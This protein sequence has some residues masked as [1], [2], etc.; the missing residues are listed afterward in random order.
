MGRTQQALHAMPTSAGLPA[1]GPW[2]SCHLGKGVVS[3]PR[4][5]SRSSLT[6]EVSSSQGLEGDLNRFLNL[7]P[8]Q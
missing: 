2:S 6:P 4:C 7:H 3:I 5:R 8:S 1:P